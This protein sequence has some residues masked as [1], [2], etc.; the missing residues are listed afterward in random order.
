MAKNKK[1]ALGK[2]LALTTTAAA[3]GGVCYVF[4]DKI[5]ESPLFKSASGKANDIYD[6]V[7]NKF[8]T[9]DEFL[10][11]DWDDDFTENPDKDSDNNTREYTT[12][13]SA[14][15]SKEDSSNKNDNDEDAI[16]TIDVNKKSEEK[17]SEDKKEENVEKYENEGLSDTYEDPDVL[18]DQDKLD[19]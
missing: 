10:F 6:S 8:N 3:I 5:A 19:F 7:R 15:D 14:K 16:P 17:K 2:L 11:D 1:S 18:E 12:I 13:S 9:E 4:K